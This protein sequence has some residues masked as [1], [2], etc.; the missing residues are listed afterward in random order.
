[1]W[2]FYSQTFPQL[3]TKCSPH[4]L[5]ERLASYFMLPHHI[6]LL[7]LNFLTDRV[8]RVF[9]NG[10]MSQAIISNTGS[11]QGCVLSPLLF[12]MYT[13]SCRASQQGSFL[14]TFSDDT[15]LLSLLQGPQSDHGSALTSF[16]EWCEDNHLDLNVIKTKELIIDFRKNSEDPIASIIHGEEVQIVDTYKYLAQC[17]TIN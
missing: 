8:Q 11:P 5:I 2:D 15:A 3:L 13:D 4:I 9:V 1:M 16:T 7:V 14:V 6:L 10:L 17:S 12:I